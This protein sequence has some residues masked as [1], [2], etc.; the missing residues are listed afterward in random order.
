MLTRNKSRSFTWGLQNPYKWRFWCCM[1]LGTATWWRGSCIKIQTKSGT[2]NWGL[3]L[4]PYLVPSWTSLSSVLLPV[5]WKT[6]SACHI[7]KMSHFPKCCSRTGE[8]R[9]RR[10]AGGAEWRCTGISFVT[11]RDRFTSTFMWSYATLG[12]EFKV[13]IEIVMNTVLLMCK[14]W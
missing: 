11:K 8:R 10:P 2:L 7:K 1:K 12:I 5:T 3:F 9:E 13:N 4:F 14:R 6:I